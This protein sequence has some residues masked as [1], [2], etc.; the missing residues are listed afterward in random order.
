MDVVTLKV[1]PASSQAHLVVAGP[2]TAWIV[3]VGD[4]IGRGQGPLPGPVHQERD[5]LYVVILVARHDVE[6]RPTK[7]L[8]DRNHHSMSSENGAEIEYHGANGQRP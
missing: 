5:V 8:L 7:L 4:V 1:V 6:D 2:R 3:G